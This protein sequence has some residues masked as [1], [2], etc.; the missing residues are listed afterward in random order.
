[1]T[2]LPDLAKSFAKLKIITD[3]ENIAQPE[4]II[5][6]GIL[7]ELRAKQSADGIIKRI[8]GQIKQNEWVIYNIIGNPDLFKRIREWEDNESDD[9]P[10][11]LFTLKH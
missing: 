1:M 3:L 11:G 10:K 2:Q 5:G 8:Q 4:T 7:T 9:I 6:L